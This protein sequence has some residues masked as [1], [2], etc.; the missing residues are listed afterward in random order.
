ME[1]R[2]ASRT[3]LAALRRAFARASGL[4]RS[5]V[6]VR[7]LTESDCGIFGDDEHAVLEVRVTPG[8]GVYHWSRTCHTEWSHYFVRRLARGFAEG[9]RTG[10]RV[11]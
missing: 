8:V 6:R 7:L 9:H 11:L 2:R 1:P 10:A 4:R 3:Q 5:Q